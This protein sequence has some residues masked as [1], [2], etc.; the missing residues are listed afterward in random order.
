MENLVHWAFLVMGLLV[1]A[2][3]IAVA[4][5]LTA[6]LGTVGFVIAAINLRMNGAL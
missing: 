1:L 6:A 3:G 5:G 2:L 4:D